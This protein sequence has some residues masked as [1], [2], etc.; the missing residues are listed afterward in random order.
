MTSH[1]AVCEGAR[2][3]RLSVC[4]ERGEKLGVGVH[5]M[6]LVH[7]GGYNIW[8]EWNLGNRV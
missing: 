7:V 2:E 6:C 5:C 4:S 1:M 3:C 8:L